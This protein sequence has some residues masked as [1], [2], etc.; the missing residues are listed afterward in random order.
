M[1][2][3]YLKDHTYPH[4]P[5]NEVTLRQLQADIAAHAEALQSAGYKLDESQRAMVA[6]AEIRRKQAEENSQNIEIP[7][8]DG[9]SF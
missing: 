4:Q 7:K 8:M 3:T 1:I 9:F 6:E 5:G 2:D